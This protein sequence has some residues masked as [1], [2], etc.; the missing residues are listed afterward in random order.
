[1]ID[2]AAMKK[3]IDEQDYGLLAGE[4]KKVKE[5]INK[6]RADK[7]PDIDFSS[8]SLE[9]I[10]QATGRNFNAYFPKNGR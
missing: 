7:Y 10:S 6:L 4:L 3:I 1:M 2:K 9:Q 5:L 8:A